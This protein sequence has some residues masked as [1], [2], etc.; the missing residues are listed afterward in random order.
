[1]L[2]RA[3]DGGIPA[4]WVTGDAVYGQHYRLR[5][6]LENRGMS[7]VLAVPTS[8]RVIGKTTMSIIGRENRADALIQSLPATAWRTRWPGASLERPSADR[9]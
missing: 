1:M 6:A 2:A 4:T 9:D 7:Y 5:K 8:Q 3:V